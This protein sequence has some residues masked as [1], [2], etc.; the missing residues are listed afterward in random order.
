MCDDKFILHR[1]ISY[2]NIMLYHSAGSEAVLHRGLLIDLDYAVRLNVI[3][4]HSEGD[5]TVS[6]SITNMLH[7]IYVSQIF[8]DAGLFTIHV[9]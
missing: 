3:R 7:V 2:N 9:T 5:W 1:D 6:A 4:D 8:I